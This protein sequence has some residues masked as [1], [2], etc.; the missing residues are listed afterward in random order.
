MR[1]D[2]LIGAI[3]QDSTFRR[4]SVAMGMTGALAAG[5]L[6]AGMLFVH[7]LGIR[8]DIAN[9]LHTW[10]FPTKV[11]IALL[12]FA[13]ALWASVQLAR[14][15][16]DRRK[17]LFMLTLPIAL[18]AV[19]TGWELVQSPPA[20][21]SARA[22]GSNSRICMV[23][24]VEMSV[25]PLGALLVALRAGAPNSPALAGAAAGLTAGGLG[26]TLYAIHCF[27]DSP[28]FVALWYLPAVVLVALVGSGVGY[29]L[30]RW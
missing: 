8:P 14:P 25:A 7:T 19:A 30:L 13:A 17:A 26:A 29:R 6:V 3:A 4:S 11:L 10:R 16:A 12:C 23:S 24:I 15:D 1:T 9:A 22:I 21:W 20:A 5:G 18:L 28:L 2:D 27:D